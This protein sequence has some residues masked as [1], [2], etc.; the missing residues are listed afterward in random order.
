MSATIFFSDENGPRLYASEPTTP[1]FKVLL[2]YLNEGG[3][4]FVF[5]ILPSASTKSL[6]PYLDGKLLRLRKDLPLVQSAKDEL[7]SFNEHFAPLFS[8]GDVISFELIQLQGITPV[9][10]AA[11]QNFQRPHHRKHDYLPPDEPYGLLVTD[12]TPG[13]GD[14]LLQV[15]PKWLSQSPNAPP[16]SRRCRTCALRAHRGSQKVRTATDKQESCPLELVSPNTLERERAATAITSDEQLREHLIHK[17]QPLLQTLR[18]AQAQLDRGGVLNLSK[19]SVGSG[20]ES[21]LDLCKAMTLRDCTLFLRRRGDHVEARLADLDVKQPEKLERW[22]QVESELIGGG[23]YTNEEGV[24][25]WKEEKV[26]L[27]S[28]ESA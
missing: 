20:G 10:N 9:L 12:M 16:R 3:A 8:P 24:E 17:S 18:K 26:C 21:I 22:R 5:S 13:P 1:S 19:D 4:N 11:L 7:A 27:L 14:I 23:W 2:E 15:K 25:V 28:R 6:P